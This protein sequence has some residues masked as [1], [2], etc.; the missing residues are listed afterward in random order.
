MQKKLL[1]LM[2]SAVFLFAL[3]PAAHADTNTYTFSDVHAS[4]TLPEGVYQTV[5]TPENLAQNEAF[6]QSQ[7]GSV[8]T[9]EADFKARGILLQA[10]DTANDRILLVTALKDV[11]GQ[12]LFDINEHP[13]DV[14]ARYRISHGA[15]GSYN[16]LGYRYDSV[17]WKSYKDIGRFL[18]LR[19]QYRLNGSVA[20]RGYQR[21]TIRNGHT[22]TVDMQVYGRQLNAQDNAALNKVFNTFTFSQILPMPVLPIS[23][24]ETQ[25]A[26]AET[27]NATFTM[28]GKTKPEA[29][30]HAVLISFSNNTTKVFDTKANKA[31][32]YSLKITLPGE[33]VYVMTLTVRK[34]GLEDFS[35]SYNIL[36]KEGILP[37]QIISAPPE[38][39]SGSQLTLS[40]ITSEAGVTAALTVNGVSTSKKVARNKEFAFDIDTARE[41]AY[42]IRLVLSKRN[43]EDRVFTY[44]TQKTVSQEAKQE[45]ERSQALRPAYADLIA[46]PNN[47]DG[48]LLRF[49]GTLIEKQNETDSWVLRFAIRKTNAGFEDILLITTDTEPDLPLNTAAAV[50]GVMTGMNIST[51]A[52]GKEYSLPKLTL[53]HLS[54]L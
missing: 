34:E 4:L 49:E 42:D 8:A 11:D 50:Y 6:I 14:R 19:Y 48:K 37:V 17:S 26:P 22:I 18:Q 46:N 44:T 27:G 38:T 54:A 12:N 5:L 39:Y 43:F 7:G 29:T 32:K 30:L 13:T 16:I 25:T 53:N 23:L 31:G 9:W 35:K 51:D 10:Y 1:L 41:G 2:L 40:G 52:D 33:D 20:H 24:D 47:Y 3:V 28:K 15:S 36:Y 21:R 45:A